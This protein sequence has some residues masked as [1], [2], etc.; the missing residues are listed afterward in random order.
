M[1]NHIFRRKAF[2]AKWIEKY[3]LA[4]ALAEQPTLDFGSTSI[5]IIALGSQFG[6]CIIRE[7]IRTQNNFNSIKNFTLINLNRKDYFKALSK[8]QVG[9]WSDCSYQD[10][11]G[12]HVMQLVLVEGRWIV[13][14]RWIPPTSYIPPAF[15]KRDCGSRELFCILLLQDLETKFSSFINQYLK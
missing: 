7:T 4:L 2:I 13:R 5:W 8:T 15:N 10:W 14:C 1:V 9:L 11:A 6:Q 12:F 3:A